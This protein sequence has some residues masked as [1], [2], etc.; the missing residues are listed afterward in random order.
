VTPLAQQER[1]ARLR[2]RRA[3]KNKDLTLLRNL[4]VSRSF[5]SHEVRVRTLIHDLPPD[6]GDLC[7][8][9]LYLS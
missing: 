1:G 3:A 6:H 9:P 8:H 4:P 5:A 2:D 7:L